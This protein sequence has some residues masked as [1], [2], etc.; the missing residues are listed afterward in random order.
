MKTARWFFFCFLSWAGFAWAEQSGKT[1]EVICRMYQ[2]RYVAAFGHADSLPGGAPAYPGSGWYAD[3][4]QTDFVGLL[5]AVADKVN[6]AAFLGKFVKAGKV[7]GMAE[8]AVYTPADLP[9]VV[10]SEANYEGAIQQIEA[11]LLKLKQLKVSAQAVELRGKWYDDF[12]YGRDCGQEEGLVVANLAALA[13]GNKVQ[14]NCDKG[15]SCPFTPGFIGGFEF[16]HAWGNSVMYPAA[17]GMISMGKLRADLSSCGTNG[18]GEVYLKLDAGTLGAINSHPNYNACFPATSAGLPI[19]QGAGVFGKW[20][21]QAPALGKIWTSAELGAAQPLPFTQTCPIAAP[22]VI[23]GSMWQIVEAVVLAS[24]NFTNQVDEVCGSCQHGVCVDPKNRSVDLQISL[25]GARYGGTAGRIVL[26]EKQPS[27]ALSTPQLLRVS[28]CEGVEVLYSTNGVLRQILAPEVF[29]DV[30]AVSPTQYSMACY[31]A[32]VAGG[33]GADGFYQAAGTAFKTIVFENPDGTNS[34]NR[35]R[36]TETDGSNS[37][38]FDYSYDPAADS[39]ELGG[40]NGLRREIRSVSWITNSVSSS[41]LALQTS[42]RVASTM[43]LKA[44]SAAMPQLTSQDLKNLGSLTNEI[45]NLC[46]PALSQTAESKAAL[47]AVAGVSLASTTPADVDRVE[48]YVVK[49]ADS[50]VAHKEITRFHVFAWGEEKIRE[51]ADPDGAALTTEWSFYDNQASDGANYGRLKQVIQPDG[52][53]ER[54]EYDA[55]GRQTKVVSAWLNAAP[56]A[57]ESSC[58]VVATTY[59]TADPAVTV[60]ETVQGREVSRRYT[61]NRAGETRDIQCQIAGAAWDNPSNLVTIRKTLLGTVFAGELQSVRQP[62]GTLSVYSYAKNGDRKTTTVKTGQ[63]DSA[64]ADVISGTRA[65]TVV[66]QAGYQLSEHVYDIA[67]GALLSSAVATQ[68]DELGRPVRIQYHDGTYETKTYGCCGLESETDREGVKTEYIHDDLKRVVAAIRDGITTLTTYDAEGRALKTIRKGRDHSEIIASRSVFNVAGQ[69]TSS[70]DALGNV[71]RFSENLNGGRVATTLFADG[72]TKVETYA[73]DG[74]ILALGGTAVH[75]VSYEYGADGD[76]VWE[77][78]IKGGEWV[79][80]YANMAGQTW[81]TVSSSGAT[82]TSYYNLKGQ[83]CKQV[84]ADGVTTLFQYNGKGELEYQA[85]DMNRNGVIDFSGPDR[86]TRQQN[87]VATAHGVTVRRA[88]GSVYGTDGSATPATVSVRETSV[89]GLREWTTQNGLTTRTQVTY[90]RA[91][92]KRTVTTVAPDGTTTTQVFQAG[93]LIS[94]KTV[95]GALGTL[96][97]TTLTYD[98]HNRPATSTDARGIAVKTN[99]NN[100]DLAIAETRRASGI[101][102][103]TSFAY[104]VMGRRTQMT[105]PDGGVVNYEYW[106]TGELKK[107]SGAKIY[108]E[109]RAWDVAGR[110][111]TLMAG[112]GVTTWN[113]VPNTALVSSKI[114]ADGKGPSYDYTPGGKLAKRTWARGVVTTYTQ[115]NAG[116]LAGVSYSDATPAVNY[117]LNR[118]GWLAAVQQG[119]NTV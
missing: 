60:V 54:Y 50:S 111:K 119:T 116:E 68:F 91:Q 104:D 71:T 36:I 3:H 41:T 26:K 2:D 15:S 14:G 27:A 77:K 13:F 99:Y 61:V 94:S 12:C 24:P 74:K 40:G 11:Q 55:Y 90:H 66:N 97:S 98:A 17:Q 109:Q 96:S 106:P 32:G 107:Q 88:T 29:V 101:E 1:L 48:T 9:R 57:A 21:G 70:T 52:N 47:A 44:V 80:R 85:V 67:T 84:D 110:L 65:V 42:A 6:S 30:S 73:R 4:G 72:S 18:S 115:N 117:T 58:R 105:Q 59:G 23:G 19:K 39:W 51:V 16:S 89:D 87:E 22:G 45:L 108:A 93:R 62:D 20:E 49:N 63:P 25:G 92:Q 33:K 81:K 43:R 10:V 103:R 102:H 5:Q 118:R 31:A 114:Y 46:S 56:G 79:K 34:V 76:G 69:Q 78:E 8:I 28:S 7:E 38:V 35:L 86:I 64:G 82:A 53:W 75:P 95:N 100:A 113:Y 112:T 37:R 83:L